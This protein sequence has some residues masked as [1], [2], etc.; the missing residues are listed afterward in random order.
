MKIQL[1]VAV[2]GSVATVFAKFDQKLFEALAPPMMP[3]T[4]RRFDGCEVGHEIHL[5]LPVGEWI[6]HITERVVGEAESFFVD[7]GRK[8]P[9]PFV[10][11]RHQ[12]IVRGAKEG[13]LLIDAIEYKTKSPL[14]DILVKPVLWA[15]FKAR[16]P[17]YRRYFQEKA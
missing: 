11:W 10:Y 7:E 15:M 9:F 8:L 6:S 13:V 17:V 12:H 16:H 14:L 5:S 1:Q 2:P 3:V 4:T